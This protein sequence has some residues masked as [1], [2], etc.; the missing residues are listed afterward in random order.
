M[1]GH[2]EGRAFGRLARDRRG[3]ALV[4]LAII[5][6]LLVLLYAGTV[7]ATAAVRAY[8]KLNAAAQTYADLIANQPSVTTS[9]LANYCAGAQLVMSP[10]NAAQLSIAAASITNSSG[11]T[12]QDWHDTTHCGTG[13]SSISG[14]SLASCP[15]ANCLTP[16]SGDTAIVVQ[17]RY[18]Y[19][20]FLRY[21]LPLSQTFTQVTSARPRQNSKISCGSCTQN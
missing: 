3:A 11:T 14:T 20:S 8:M 16:N 12:A 4:E 1:T 5:A 7:E 21:V 6:P 9:S 17:A 19:T 13:V 2:G 15:G 10:L 18:T